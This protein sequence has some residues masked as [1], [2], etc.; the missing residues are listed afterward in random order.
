[1]DS[2]VSGLEARRQELEKAVKDLEYRQGGFASAVKGLE[3]KKAELEKRI[4][5]LEQVRLTQLV[6]GFRQ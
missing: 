6:Q 3:Q 2:D 5:L 1:M 4:S